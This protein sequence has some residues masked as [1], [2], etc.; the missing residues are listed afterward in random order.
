MGL[1]WS[2]DGRQLVSPPDRA[3][4]AR[5]PLRDNARARQRKGHPERARIAR[6]AASLTSSARTATSSASG[7]RPRLRPRGLPGTRARGRPG[8]R[9]RRGTR[10]SGSRA[11][12]RPRGS[13]VPRAARTASS[14]CE[15]APSLAG[16]RAAQEAELVR[17][18]ID[19]VR[20][21]RVPLDADRR[22][23]EPGR[24][25]RQAVGLAGRERRL[26][27]WGPSG[28]RS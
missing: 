12:R 15:V 21:T 2:P 27:W 11:R 20:D 18:Q 1:D 9:S 3:G 16:A 13:R 25:L 22:V 5:P 14:P 19:V 17:R 28:C 8:S 10:S 6:L 24:L 23:D 26:G 4:C 7:F